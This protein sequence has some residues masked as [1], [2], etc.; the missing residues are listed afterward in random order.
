MGPRDKQLSYF[1]GH[2]T[3]EQF[4]V[5]GVFGPLHAWWGFPTNRKSGGKEGTT[6][7]SLGVALRRN[8]DVGSIK[9]IRSKVEA[10]LLV[11][12]QQSFRSKIKLLLKWK[13]II[14][15]C[16]AADIVQ[17]ELLLKSFISSFTAD[18]MALVGLLSL[19]LCG[20]LCPYNINW[21]CAILS[22]GT[23]FYTD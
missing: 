22:S 23:T 8:N 2:Y 9:A 14:P 6:V 5:R 16:L 10:L 21:P 1:L 20:P 4:F 7:L 11:L 13:T 18:I 19:F 17:L 12:S 15:H 3:Q